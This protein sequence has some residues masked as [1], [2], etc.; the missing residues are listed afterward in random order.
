[1]DI[2]DMVRVALLPPDR[3]DDDLVQKS[4]TIINKSPYITVYSWLVKYPELSVT[5]LLHNRLKHL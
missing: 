5:I 3:V 2:H 1:M 4:A